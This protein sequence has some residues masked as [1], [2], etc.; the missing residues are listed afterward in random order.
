LS[1]SK[2]RGYG[3]DFFSSPD[4]MLGFQSKAWGE[5]GFSSSPL[6]EAGEG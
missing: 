4:G 3:V 5:D 2:W 1:L 6:G